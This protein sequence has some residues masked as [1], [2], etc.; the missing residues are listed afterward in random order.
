MGY[1]IIGAL[2][3]GKICQEFN[4][5]V[6]DDAN[7]AP[8]QPCHVIQSPNRSCQHVVDVNVTPAFQTT[9]NNASM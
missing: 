7:V 3:R 8:Q 2:L 9:K 4:S 1:E 5:Y 6:P